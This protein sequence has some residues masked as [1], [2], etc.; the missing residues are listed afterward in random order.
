MAIEGGVGLGPSKESGRS[1]VGMMEMV[2]FNDGGTA[3]PE[4]NEENKGKD[5]DGKVGGISVDDS[6]VNE[7]VE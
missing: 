1:R 4:G 7:R 5:R 2:G 3:S 6:D